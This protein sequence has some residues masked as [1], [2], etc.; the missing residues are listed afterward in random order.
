MYI[1]ASRSRRVAGM[2]RTYGSAAPAHRSRWQYD[3]GSGGSTVPVSAGTSARVIVGVS[4]AY[5]RNSLSGRT[6]GST[7]PARQLVRS[8]GS[9]M[10]ASLAVVLTRVVVDALSRLG[11]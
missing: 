1:G 3:V 11:S 8:V 5:R 6:N 9:T 10:P 4:H 2:C 7:V